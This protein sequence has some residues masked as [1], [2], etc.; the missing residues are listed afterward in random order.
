MESNKHER[1]AEYEALA[2]ICSAL[3]LVE[4]SLNK[5]ERVTVADMAE[6][7]FLSESHFRR[8]FGARMG[9]SPKG[10]LTRK[11]LEK[12]A[13]LLRNGALSVSQIS[14]SCGFRNHSTFYRDFVKHYGCNPSEYR[15]K[16]L[17]K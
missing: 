4:E 13:I 2:P 12:A 3:R 11:R 15:E 16:N 6:A 17:E 5:G 8:V 10:Y 1:A 9:E 14:W 7:C